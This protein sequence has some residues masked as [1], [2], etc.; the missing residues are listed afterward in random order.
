M[1]AQRRQRRRNARGRAGSGRR[2]GRARTPPRGSH[3]AWRWCRP[4]V[5]ARCGK[6]PAA[7]GGRRG[8]RAGGGRSRPRGRGARRSACRSGRRPPPR[9]RAA[10]AGR[11]DRCRYDRV[12][13]ASA[14]R[15]PGQPSGAGGGSSLAAA[16]GG[17]AAVGA[18]LDIVSGR[19]GAGTDSRCA[20]ACKP[21]GLERPRPGRRG[22]G[23]LGRVHCP[24]SGR[25]R[26]SLGVRGKSHA[27]IGMAESGKK[28]REGVQNA[29]ISTNGAKCSWYEPQRL[30][31]KPR[32]MSLICI[33]SRCSLAAFASI[34]VLRVKFFCFAARAAP[35]SIATRTHDATGD[36]PGAQ[37]CIVSW[38]LPLLPAPFAPYGSTPWTSPPS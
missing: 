21:R 34:F 27:T 19:L 11:A 4:A 2:P 31:C 7:A 20:G 35:C 25:L 13:R 10:S 8:G 29:R 24:P 14:G 26:R 16:G 18:G 6:T 1:R 22:P 37:L 5:P 32:R 17:A 12:R 38:F 33:V 3:P 28:P 30:I 9:G 23:S 15:P 36:R